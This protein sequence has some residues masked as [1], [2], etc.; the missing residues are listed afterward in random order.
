[1]ETTLFLAQFWGWLM[2]ITCLLLL[3]NKKAL[4]SMMA[5]MK[6]DGFVFL[7]GFMALVLGLLTVL[8]HNVWVSDWPVVVTLFGWASLLKGA[9]RVGFPKATGQMVAKF[10]S[11]PGMANV[12]LIVGAL[13]GGWLIWVS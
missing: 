2:V 7:T 3:A 5:H 9:L 6:D 12:M 11:N 8:M 13:V 4:S 10:T 1:M